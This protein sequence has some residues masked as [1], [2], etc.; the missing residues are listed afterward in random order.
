VL[1]EEAVRLVTTGYAAVP[2][3]SVA[4][5]G[6]GVMIGQRH[7]GDPVW[8]HGGSINGFDAQVTMYPRQRLAFVLLDNR[9]GSPMTGIAP[10]GLREIAKLP[11]APESD[12]PVERVASARERAQLVGRYAQN[13]IRLE[14]VEQGDS[15]LFKQGMAQLPVRLVGDDRIVLT[16]PV[17]NK[18]TLVLVRDET[19]RV[20]YLS[21]GLRAIARQP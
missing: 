20:A 17:G 2:G 11:L 21:Q 18:I 13:R 14:I 6:Y 9:S 3:D 12:D 15:L 4:R 10:V 16:P 5:Y 7:T 8:Q 19:G 1:S